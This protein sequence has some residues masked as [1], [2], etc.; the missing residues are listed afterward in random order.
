MNRERERKRC[1]KIPLPFTGAP[2]KKM[3]CM[4][5]TT[6]SKEQ[7]QYRLLTISV[8][9]RAVETSSHTHTTCVINMKD[10][11]NI[12]PKRIF[13]D[14]SDVHKHISAYYT[15]PFQTNIDDRYGVFI[16]LHQ[17]MR[18]GW[19]FISRIDFHFACK[20]IVRDRA[21]YNRKAVLFAE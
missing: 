20:S 9:D 6:I 11:H 18:L 12:W 19:R 7:R 15:Q 13:R 4:P 5:E 17:W 21:P 14:T 8:F 3:E 16:W 2:V 10:N 1:I